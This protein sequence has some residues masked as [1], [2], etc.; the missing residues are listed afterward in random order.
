[1]SNAYDCEH[2]REN[3]GDMVVER[4]V[5]LEDAWENA[6]EVWLLNPWEL[7]ILGGCGDGIW[8]LTIPQPHGPFQWCIVVVE[9][10]MDQNASICCTVPR[11]WILDGDGLVE[12]A[13]RCPKTR[14][15]DVSF[16][17][18][19]VNITGWIPVVFLSFFWNGN[20]VSL[21]V[22]TGELKNPPGRLWWTGKL[23]L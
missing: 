14:S 13:R 19:W 21:P 11:I 1:M 10:N 22:N 23:I 9:L 7:W 2:V 12:W 5:L 6:W 4:W 8:V 3:W 18:L 15:M 20:W 17:S 16:D